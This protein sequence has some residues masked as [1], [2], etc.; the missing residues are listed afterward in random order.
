MPRF[1]CGVQ[2]SSAGPDPPRALKGTPPASVLRKR[3]FHKHL[4]GGRRCPRAARGLGRAETRADAAGERRL[5][6]PG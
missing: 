6:H 1:L 5:R 3:L 4:A 2:S